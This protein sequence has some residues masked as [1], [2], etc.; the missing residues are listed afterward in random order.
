MA[1]Q[2]TRSATPT[3]SRWRTST[4]IFQMPT[5]SCHKGKTTDVSVQHPKNWFQNEKSAKVTEPLENNWQGLTVT[6]ATLLWAT[7]YWPLSTISFCLVAPVGISFSCAYKKILHIPGPWSKIFR[8][9]EN[10]SAVGLIY[11]IKN[12]KTECECGVKKENGN[13]SLSESITQ[14]TLMFAPT[15]R[16]LNL[17]ERELQTSVRSWESE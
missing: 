6:V 13:G 5:R 17:I 7:R 14:K 11:S 1:E 4:A 10:R 3:L 8:Q 15:P 2:M 9:G 16:Q 12:S